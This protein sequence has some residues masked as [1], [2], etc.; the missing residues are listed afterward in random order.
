MDSNDFI[1]LLLSLMVALPGKKIIDFCE[2]IPPIRGKSS[3][4]GYTYRLVC[5]QKLIKLLS[6]PFPI[7]FSTISVI[8]VWQSSF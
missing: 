4:I 5:F 3:R 1:L 2:L 6:K 7:R 8:F